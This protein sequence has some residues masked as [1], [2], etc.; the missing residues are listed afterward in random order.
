MLRGL[1]AKK[2]RYFY[3]QHIGSQRQVLMESENK[4]GWLH[5]FTENYVKVRFPYDAAL[6]NQTRQVTLQQIADDGNVDIVMAD[7]QIPA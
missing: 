3:D 1:S 4:D 2:R 5:G 6:I 7:E